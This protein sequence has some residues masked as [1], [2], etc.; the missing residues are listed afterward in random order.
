MIFALLDIFLFFWAAWAVLTATA[1]WRYFAWFLVIISAI[2]G[3]QDLPKFV[4]QDQTLAA[5]GELA[6]IGLPFWLLYETRHHRNEEGSRN[7][8]PSMQ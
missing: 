4:M 6:C 5:F 3:L 7:D 1:P 2:D 8:H